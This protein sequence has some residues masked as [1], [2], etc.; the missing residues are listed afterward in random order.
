M[1]L[2]AEAAGIITSGVVDPQRFRMLTEMHTDAAGTRQSLLNQKRVTEGIAY[3]TPQHDRFIDL[4]I[5][6]DVAG[7]RWAHKIHNKLDDGTTASRNYTPHLETVSQPSG[8]IAVLKLEVADHAALAAL[9]REAFRQTCP[10]GS[11]TANDYTDSILKSG[12]K[13]PLM[14]VVLRVIYDN[15]PQDEHYLMSI[16]GNSRL[17]SMWKA[18]TGGDID[19]A[20]SACIETVI[21]APTHSGGWRSISPR[22]ARDRV[23]ATI[24]SIGRGL[25]ESKLTEATIRAGQTLTAPAVVVVGGCNNEGGPLSD[26]VA[27]REDMLATIHTEA[28]PWDEQA[29]A[30]R[31]MSRVL[32]RAAK[33]GLITADERAVVEGQYTPADM[34]RKL[35]LPPHRLWAAA[36]TLELVLAR[37]DA[38]MGQLFREE[39]N[40][41]RPSRLSVGDRIAATSLSGYRSAKTLRNATN[42]FSNGGPITD[43]VWERRYTWELD[44]GENPNA[45]LDGLL[46][47]SL[48]GDIYA[49]VQLSVLGGLAGMLEGL[50]TRDRGSKVPEDHRRAVGKAPFRLQTYRIV[51]GLAKTKGG[52]KILH[53][54]AKSHINGTPAK[55][56]YTTVDP[57]DHLD[58]EPTLDSAGAQVSIE[59][60][61]EIVA[62]A[63]PM[64][65]REIQDAL[66]LAAEAA[67]QP[68]EVQLRT[69]L[70]TSAAGVF[71]ATRDLVAIKSSRGPEVFGSVETIREIKEQLSESRDL[72]TLHAT[73]NPQLPLDDGDDDTDD[74]A[75]E[76]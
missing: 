28:T 9:V 49:I 65:A 6:P 20:A 17:V 60:E 33:S 69:Q 8:A 12:V 74:V 39:F 25:S 48:K 35:G 59:M 13:E 76:L 5:L 22:Q 23:S 42:A 15:N 64:R 71:K 24:E 58:G 27:A 32:R 1:N 61:W 14:L 54:L 38:G 45:V 36:L 31:G 3:V 47:K 46:R 72:L 2:D 10:D 68:K 57:A 73:T 19:A 51:E 30:E 62:A 37:W 21:G 4:G 11:Q 16:D 52:L 18:R 29:Q 34:H 53:S 50:I 67:N 55:L 56:F 63:D 44:P 41:V 43:D 26:L 75:D 40:L 70:R 7:A 66:P